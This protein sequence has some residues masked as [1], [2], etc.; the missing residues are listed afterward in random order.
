[1]EDVLAELRLSFGNGFRHRFTRLLSRTGID[2]P[3]FIE[4]RLIYFIDSNFAADRDYTRDLMT[5]L[6][7]MDVLWWA[8]TTVDVAREPDFLDR[9][10]RSGCLALNIGFESL[11][12]E[13]LKTMHKS[14]AGGYNYEEAIRIIHDFDIGIMGTFVI[15]FDGEDA[16]IFD[17]IEQ[18]VL[19]N[20]L[21]WALVFI[22]TPYP[23]T[24]LF[25]DLEHEGR[26]V[27]KEWEKYDTL[28]CVYTPLGMS[29]PELETGVRAL[30]KQI[31]SLKS[32]TRR[33]LSR[34]RIH[35]MF[36]LGMNMQ[37]YA[38]CRRW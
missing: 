14:F 6:E 15:G 22:R 10:R 35:P 16:S 36:Y 33:I 1:M 37:F 12:K 19:K 11:S 5:Q 25:R 29:I 26:L 20:R 23:G 2:L 30:W 18:F 13:N 28:N 32:I 27:T 21:D 9:M 24:T 17:R 4:R 38:M 3:Y 34:P 7:S 31:F 8:H